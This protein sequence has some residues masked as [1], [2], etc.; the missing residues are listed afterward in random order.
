MCMCVCVCVCVCEG[1]YWMNDFLKLG[2]EKL[3]P[4]AA[5]MLE[6]ILYCISD[7]ETE[8]RSQA[9]VCVCVCVCVCV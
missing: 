4:F 8:I 1:L 7:T 9:G 5:Y 3:L 6:A 2:K